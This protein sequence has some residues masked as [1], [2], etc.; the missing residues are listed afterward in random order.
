[1]IYLDATKREAAIEA[2]WQAYAERV[3]GFRDAYLKAAQ[4]WDVSA[5]CA[6]SEV[7]GALFSRRGVIHLGIKPEWRGRWASRRVIREML[8]H[9]SQTTLMDGE[10]DAFVRRIGFQKIGDK[11]EFCR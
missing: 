5:V 8:K 11:Y 6:D 9:G 1:M 4:D 3:P 10:D 2:G 7:I